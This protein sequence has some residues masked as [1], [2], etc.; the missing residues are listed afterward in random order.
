M[1]LSIH[2]N[3]VDT[4]NDIRADIAADIAFEKSCDQLAIP[5][6]LAHCRADDMAAL[7]RHRPLINGMSI[8]GWLTAIKSVT[9]LD[10][11]SASTKALAMQILGAP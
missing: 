1:Q 4:P 3:D 6:I 10:G 2:L 7:A 9:E 5:L 11:V 8:H